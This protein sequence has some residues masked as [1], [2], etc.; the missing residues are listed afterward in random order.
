MIL[1]EDLF[2]LLLVKILLGH[3]IAAVFVVVFVVVQ[4]LFLSSFSIKNCIIL[5]RVNTSLL[6]PFTLEIRKGLFS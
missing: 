4:H 6:L 3:I 1:S 2:H 5:K